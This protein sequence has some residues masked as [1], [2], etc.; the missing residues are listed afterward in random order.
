MSSKRNIDIDN[1]T[2]TTTKIKKQ[3]VTEASNDDDKKSSP[4]KRKF[5]PRDDDTKSKESMPR[6]NITPIPLDD[7]KKYL[8]LISWNVAGLRGLLKNKPNI[9]N[10]IVDKH[11][12]DVFCLQEHKLQSSHLADFENLLESKGYTGYWTCSDVKKGYSGVVVF[13]KGVTPKKKTTGTLTSMWSKKNDNSNDKNESNN[14]TINSN[15]NVIDVKFDLED[16]K[17]SGEGR[18]ITIEFENFYFIGCYV[19]N[20][21]QN[22]ERLDYRVDEWDP[23]MRNYL[24]ELQ[25]KKPIVFAGDLNCGYADIDIHNPTAKHIV[26]QAGLT[27]RERSSFGEFFNIGFVD[28]LRYFYPNA[29]GQFTY[30]SQRTF[31][32]EVN[33]GIRLDYF[34]CSNSMAPDYD[35]E[36]NEGEM[37]RQ[38]VLNKSYNHPTLHDTY[39]L[40]TDTIGSSDHCPVVLVLQK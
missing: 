18:T 37:R 26:K 10:D 32:R 38:V 17:F 20:S 19:P 21:G 40:D 28:A 9:I 34:I 4:T 30:W 39:I 15:L 35:K 11:S 16:K 2:A 36:V 1:D 25:K 6:D 23:Y 33:K 24:L 13:V 12:P 27:P 14:E 29:I 31:A 7:T 5:G 3:K 22:L 8:K